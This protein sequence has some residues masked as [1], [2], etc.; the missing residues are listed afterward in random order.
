LATV[1]LKHVGNGLQMETTAESYWIR[2]VVVT[3]KLPPV[4]PFPD[5]VRTYELARIEVDKGSTRC[6]LAGYSGLSPEDANRMATG[7]LLAGSRA[8]HEEAERIKRL[9][10]R[11]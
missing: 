11:R 5:H 3:I 8:A 4:P 2:T 10:K 7:Y 1:T 9:E 6:T